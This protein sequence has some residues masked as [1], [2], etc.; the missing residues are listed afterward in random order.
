MGDLGL[1]AHRGDVGQGPPGVFGRQ[2]ELQLIPGLQQDVRRL[3]QPL[4][5][6][7]VGSLAEIPALGVL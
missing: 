1:A 5:D 2:P 6:G 4:A 7:P 3:H